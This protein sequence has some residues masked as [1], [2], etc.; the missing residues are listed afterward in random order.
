MTLSQLA[1]LDAQP[2]KLEITNPFTDEKTGVAFLVNPIKSKA[3]NNAKHALN[4]KYLELM[5][6]DS[7]VED[8]DGTKTLKLEI[9]EALSREMYAN[10]VVDWEGVTDDKGKKL[11]FDLNQCIAIFQDSTE[12]AMQVANF[13]NEMGKS[14]T[15]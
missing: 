9:M 1:S 14:L 12:I 10:L 5:Q 3:G 15:K 8:K 11:P 4:V 2:Q 7:N 6:D 13:V